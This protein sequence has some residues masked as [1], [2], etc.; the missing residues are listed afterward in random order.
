MTKPATPFSLDASPR[1]ELASGYG[2]P[3]AQKARRFN[4]P[5]EACDA[6]LE[7][8]S[9]GALLLRQEG[10]ILWAN[11]R[12]AQLVAKPLS[13]ITEAPWGQLFTPEDQPRLDKLLKHPDATDQREEFTFQAPDGV[14][15]TVTVS[16]SQ[17]DHDQG[18]LLAAILSD[19]TGKKAAENAL[20]RAGELQALMDALPALILIER[21]SECRQIESTRSA[22]ELLS[23]NLREN[24]ASPSDQPALRF[25]RE[26]C[27][28][29]PESTP[30]RIAA[31]GQPVQNC[32]FDLAAPDGRTLTFLGHAAPLPTPLGGTNG[33]AGVFI[34]ITER[35]RAES[36][37]L[38]MNRLE[39]TAALAGGIAHDFNNL[40][41]AILLNLDLIS[42][43]AG[44]GKDVRPYANAARAGAIAAH[45]LTRQLVAF[46]RAGAPSRKP[47]LLNHI[48]EAAAAVALSGSNV[49]A[50]IETQP[51]LHW[52][53]ADES[54]IGQVLRNLL[55]NA[56][57][58]MPNGGVVTLR[59]R[60]TL[61]SR[62]SAP[63][64]P[65]G[66]YVRVEVA[67]QGS[68]IP[69]ES[70]PKIF[71]P[72][73]ST[74]PRG[75][76]K[77]MGLGLTICHTIIKQHG[78]AIEADSQQ[79]AG[80]VFTIHLPACPEPPD[81]SPAP[82]KAQPTNKNPK[83]ILVMDDEDCMRLA[84]QCVLRARG[85]QVVTARDG[86]E[87]LALFTAAKEQN[88]PFDLVMLDLTIRGGMGGRETLTA[89]LQIEPKLKSIVMS[90]YPDDPVLAHP[91]RYGFTAGMEKSF[92]AEELTAAVN[93]VLAT[94]TD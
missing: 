90:G 53:D 13:Q 10:K 65:T 20:R 37:R 70:L 40:L 61:L 28:L 5:S 93:R 41:N 7:R 27:E 52:I 80:A 59:A 18:R 8:I 6:L 22:R 34:D 43:D 14:R 47:V 42:L 64:L 1:T 11:E 63:G 12:T 26:G 75:S 48:I 50:Q 69:A 21:D 81:Q 85:F 38:L 2:L 68:G 30:M 51:G 31:R 35:K 56:R 87:T 84:I 94:K 73:Y 25:M 49:L 62:E 86:H 72:Y 58:A 17:L 91:H 54:L 4:T 92:N 66:P 9:E 3:Q 45:A 82:A 16:L 36:D 77:G 83:K 46:A 88:S 44:T 76:D 19:V 67:D 74:K 32:E 60:N 71:D 39:S 89:L 24:T 23:A 78:G 57:E 79:G 33:A 55:F 15:R 29:P